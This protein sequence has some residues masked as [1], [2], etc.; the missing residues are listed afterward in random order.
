MALMRQIPACDKAMHEG[1]WPLPMTRVLHRK[2]IGS[3]VGL[4]NIGKYVARIA[5]AFGMMSLP[6]VAG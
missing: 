3:I 5:N 2:T 4:G 1:T 6:G